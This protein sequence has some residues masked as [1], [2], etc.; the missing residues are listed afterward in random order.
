MMGTNTVRG[1]HS[2]AR[3]FAGAGVKCGVMDAMNTPVPDS[4]AYCNKCGAANPQSA[5]VCY[6]C[7]HVHTRLIELPPEE[8]RANAIELWFWIGLR[9]TCGVALCVGQSL[10][11]SGATLDAALL[12]RIVGSTAIPVA[13]GAVLGSGSWARSSRWFLGAALVF[14]IVHYLSVVFGR[15]HLR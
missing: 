2:F 15:I 9:I 7:G 5:V 11:T 6:T 8:R 4:A 13:I 14:P 12:G 3:R 10:P 1:G